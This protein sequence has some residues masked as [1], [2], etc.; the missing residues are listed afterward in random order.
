M[1]LMQ[2]LPR[3]EA[4]ASTINYNLIHI[5]STGLSFIVCSLLLSFFYQTTDTVFYYSLIFAISFSLL[6]FV[7]YKIGNKMLHSASHYYFKKYR[8]RLMRPLAV[9]FKMGMR[10]VFVFYQ[11]KPKAFALS[12]FIDM[13]ARFVEGLTFYLGFRMIKSPISLL[14]SSLLDV[15]RTLLDTIFFFIPYQIGSREKSVHLLMEKILLIDSKGFLTVVLF[16]RFVEIFWI[17]IGYLIWVS[18]KRSVNEVK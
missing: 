7:L 17:I 4:F 10:R 13:I 3:S 11:Q 8:F 1:M 6:I 18:S 16:Y 14:S 15:G 2:H 9:N 5:L 12:L